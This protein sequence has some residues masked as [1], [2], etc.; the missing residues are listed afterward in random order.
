MRS[1][2]MKIEGDGFFVRTVG[3]RKMLL[4]MESGGERRRTLSIE[5]HS[6]KR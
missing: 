4:Q 1:K 3:L 6:T 5:R 2:E